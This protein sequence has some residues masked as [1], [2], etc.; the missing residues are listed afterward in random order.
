VNLFEEAVGDLCRKRGNQDGFGG[1]ALKWGRD[2]G[3]R[4]RKGRLI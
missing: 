2:R 4:D 1:S 3:P